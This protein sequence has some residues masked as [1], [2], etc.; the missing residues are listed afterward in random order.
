MRANVHDMSPA[1]VKTPRAECEMAQIALNR[2]RSLAAKILW[3]VMI[4]FGCVA[5]ISIIVLAAR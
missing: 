4:V 2:P 3:T 5:V 1:L